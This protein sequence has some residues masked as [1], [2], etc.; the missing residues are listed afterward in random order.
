MRKKIIT[1]ISGHKIFNSSFNSDNINI[2]SQELMPKEVVYNIW[3][4]RRLISDFV[5]KELSMNIS[6]YKGNKVMVISLRY[7][8][9]SYLAMTDE[10]ITYLIDL[11]LLPS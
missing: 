2:I 5:P 7:F 9:K 8:N 4:R 3:T 10:K 6:S 11:F 1:L